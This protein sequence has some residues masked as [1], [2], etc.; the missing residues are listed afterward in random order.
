M[1]VHNF[2]LAFVFSSQAAKRKRNEHNKKLKAEKISSRNEPKLINCRLGPY[3]TPDTSKYGSIIAKEPAPSTCWT[4][5]T[6][7]DHGIEIKFTAKEFNDV[8]TVKKPT[9]AVY[10]KYDDVNAGVTSDREINLCSEKPTA[11]Y[12]TYG[13]WIYLNGTSQALI[14]YKP[15]DSIKSNRFSFLHSQL[16]VNPFKIEWQCFTTDSSTWRRAIGNGWANIIRDQ[17]DMQER[18]KIKL[19]KIITKLMIQVTMKDKCL[20]EPNGNTL[21]RIENSDDISKWVKGIITLIRQRFATCK[22]TDELQQQLTIEEIADPKTIRHLQFKQSQAKNLQ[23]K[24][25]SV[26]EKFQKFI[27]AP[28]Q[29]VIE[30]RF[31]R[32][33]V[34]ARK[35]SLKQLVE[36]SS[37]LKQP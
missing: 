16:A 25:K 15:T 27:E 2:L 37:E 34:R 19:H 3:D 22:M 8:C 12:V 4:I 20:S 30:A 35:L 31:T 11:E 5:D 33:T 9:F 1:R 29:S 10:V 7:C 36:Q 21:K 6:Y 32:R 23:N 26:I 13:D 17:S 24:A 18:F 14:A 28:P